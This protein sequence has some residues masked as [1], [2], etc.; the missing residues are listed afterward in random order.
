M[1]DGQHQLVFERLKEFLARSSL[2]SSTSDLPTGSPCDFMNVYAMA[3]PI[4]SLST[5]LPR[6]AITSIL[7]DTFAPPRIATQGRGGFLVA[8]V[9]YFNSCSMSSPAA[10]CGT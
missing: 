2:S 1:V 8:M 6:F 3:P 9:R 7:S 4:N 10:A 5:T